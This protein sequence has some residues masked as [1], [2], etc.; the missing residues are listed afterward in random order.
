MSAKIQVDEIVDHLSS[1][2]RSALDMSVQ[3][4]IPGAKFDSTELFREF[5]RAISSRRSTWEKVPDRYVDV[6]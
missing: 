6:K 1:E 5:N 2:F 3:R 4:A